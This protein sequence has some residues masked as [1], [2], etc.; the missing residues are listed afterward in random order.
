MMQKKKH[1]KYCGALYN[2]E[3]CVNCQRKLELIRII[4][5][6]VLNKKKEVEDNG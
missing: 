5:E 1:C 6:M 3:I 4:K 2:T